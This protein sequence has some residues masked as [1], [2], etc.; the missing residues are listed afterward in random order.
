[1]DGLSE[2]NLRLAKPWNLESLGG[3]ISIR[4]M[5]NKDRVTKPGDARI[6]K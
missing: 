1:M 2:K 5:V 4:S 6:Q 3:V